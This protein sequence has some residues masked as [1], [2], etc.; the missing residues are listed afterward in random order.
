MDV[1]VSLLHLVQEHDAVGPAAHGLRQHAAPFVAD[2]AG[3]SALERGDGVSL[4]ELAHVDGD[5]IFL[6]AVERLGQRQRRLR[7]AHA[8]RPHQEEHPDGLLGIV[9]ASSRG[10][11]ALGDHLEAVALAHDARAERVDELQDG[12]DL[13]LDH[14][15]HR[16]PRPVGHDGGHGLSIDAGQ[17]QRGIALRLG[18]GRLQPA[19]L[20]QPRLAHRRLLGLGLVAELPA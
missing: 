1:G 18:E 2:V 5:D 6:A 16:D 14:P 9:E 19:Q 17:D 20:G 8:R 10:L 13:V 15:A 3:R 4:L 11:D 12:L 7:L